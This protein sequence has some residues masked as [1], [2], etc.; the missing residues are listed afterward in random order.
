[1][2]N[3]YHQAPIQLADAQP[4]FFSQAGQGDR[5]ERPP[6]KIERPPV[7][8]NCGIDE[9]EP[10]G[11]QHSNALVLGPLKIHPQQIYPRS[12]V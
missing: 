9:I 11:F 8:Q 10:A 1:M 5:I 4:A 7:K 2:S 6:V 3:S 12:W